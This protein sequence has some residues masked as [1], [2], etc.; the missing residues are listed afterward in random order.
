MESAIME[1]WQIVSKLETYERK[2]EILDYV[3][4]ILRL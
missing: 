4:I 2:E 1:L 3:I